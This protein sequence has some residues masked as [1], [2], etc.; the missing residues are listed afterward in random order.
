MKSPA[1]GGEVLCLERGKTPPG[2]RRGLLSATAR[3]R[4]EDQKGRDPRWKKEGGEGGEGKAGWEVPVKAD[5]KF[6]SKGLMGGL[7]E[8]THRHVLGE[9]QK[10]SFNFYSCRQKVQMTIDLGVR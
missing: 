2:H 10:F 8:V 5:P 9:L 6:K 1:V 7:E 4:P 3:E